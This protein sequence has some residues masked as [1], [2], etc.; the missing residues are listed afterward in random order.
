MKA[1]RML[2]IPITAG[3]LAFVGELGHFRAGQ[4]QR[5]SAEWALVL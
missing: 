3:V 1:R 2:T 5:E 4:V